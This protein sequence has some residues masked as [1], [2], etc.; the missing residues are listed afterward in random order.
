MVK[1][2]KTSLIYTENYNFEDVKEFELERG[3]ETFRWRTFW[4]W[5]DFCALDWSWASRYSHYSDVEIGEREDYDS[6][7]EETLAYKKLKLCS[8]SN[9]LA[10]TEP[11]WIRGNIE[12]TN[13]HTSKEFRKKA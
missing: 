11:D 1:R 10:I 13:S 7:D 12:Y 9:N 3:G 4:R 8:V 2:G 6:S 5:F